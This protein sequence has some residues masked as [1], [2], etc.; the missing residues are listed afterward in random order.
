MMTTVSTAMSTIPKHRISATECTLSAL[1]LGTV[2]FGR[3][4]SVKYPSEFDLPSDQA[5]FDLLG[6]CRDLGLTSLDTAPAYGMAEQR[7]GK[8]LKG[9]RKD[10]EIISKAGEHYHSQSQQSTYDF[11]AKALNQQLEQSLRTLQTDYLDCW[12]LHSNGDDMQNLSDEVIHCMQQAKQAGKVLSVGLSGKTVA[13]GKYALTHL[14][15]IMMTASLN[16]H[17]EDELFELASANAKHVVLKKIF[18][19]GWMMQ[20]ESDT[21]KQ[22]LLIESFAYLFAKP[23][24]ASAVIGTINPRHLLQ[25]VQ[26]FNNSQG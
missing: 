9:Q 26:A 2:K 23:A 21:E 11:S 15:T 20:T 5:L 24:V 10:F 14:D 8:L 19:S 6:Q 17:D 16:Y 12:L 25:N 18:D 22:R 13:G 4:Q 7:L 1:S 3:N